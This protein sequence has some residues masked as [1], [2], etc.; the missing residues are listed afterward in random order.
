MRKFHFLYG[1]YSVFFFLSLSSCFSTAKI[2]SSKPPITSGWRIGGT[3]NKVGICCNTD[4]NVTEDGDTLQNWI[5]VFSSPIEIKHNDNWLTSKSEDQYF[6]AKLQQPVKFW[7][8]S[9]K[10][11]QKFENIFREL[12]LPDSLLITK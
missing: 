10:H 9:L 11:Y 8:F 2:I 3:S 7:K 5:L 6:I 4:W 12:Q 1:L